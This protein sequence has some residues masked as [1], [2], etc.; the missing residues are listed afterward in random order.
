MANLINSII[1]YAL[2]ILKKLSPEQ[3]VTLNDYPV[4]NEQILKLYFRM[5]HKGQGRIV[6]PCP[7]MPKSAGIPLMRGNDKKINK[8]NNL[9]RKFIKSHPKAE[10]FLLDGTHKTTAATLAHKPIPAIIF[11]TDKDI[12]EAKKLVENGEIFSLTTGQTIK[13]ELESLKRHFFKT[14]LFQTVKGKTIKMCKNKAIPKY[15]IDFYRRKYD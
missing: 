7:V 9:L 10:Y 11:K 8:Y 12:R 14:M 2:M 5:F 1:E 13:S 3:I 15:M 6:P 4:H